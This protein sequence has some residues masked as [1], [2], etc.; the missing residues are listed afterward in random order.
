MQQV[1]SMV[2]P[3]RMQLLFLIERLQQVLFTRFGVPAQIC[4]E[5]LK[6]R[7]AWNMQGSGWKGFRPRGGSISNASV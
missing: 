1:I 2:T 4:T 5:Q 3:V 7:V 6:G